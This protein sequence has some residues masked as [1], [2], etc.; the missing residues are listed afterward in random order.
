MHLNYLAD[1]QD[2]VLLNFHFNPEIIIF[3]ES[4][5]SLDEATRSNIKN[6]KQN[7]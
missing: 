1:A 4:T 6:Y 3:D 2:L 7:L 5:N